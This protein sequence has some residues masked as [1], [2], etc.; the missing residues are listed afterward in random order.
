MEKI[1]VNDI[2]FSNLKKMN[3]VGTKS[4]MYTKDGICIKMFKELYPEEKKDMYRKFL[5]MDGLDIDGVILP[6]DLIV[7][8][9]K[10]QGYT[11][12]YFENSEPLFKR[13]GRSNYVDCREMFDVVKNASLI[14]RRIHENKF[15]CQDLNFDNILIDDSGTIKYCDI[16]G[17]TYNGISSPYMSSLLARYL[18]HRRKEFD[19]FSVNSDRVSLILSFFLLAY[20]KEIQKVS[21]REYCSL[22]GSLQTLKNME[23][24]ADSLCLKGGNLPCVP[25]IDELIDDNDSGYINREKQIS[26]FRRVFRR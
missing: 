17:C 2:D 23:E 7:D 26:L 25:Y 8:G 21:N 14:L 19:D 9:D 3:S 18:S 4:A 22:S 12:E 5:S 11:M 10:L 13:F 24:Y 6:K 1:R 15:V 20:T 16:D